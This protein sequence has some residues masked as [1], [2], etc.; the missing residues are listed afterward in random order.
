[1]VELNWNWS[2][3]VEF[4]LENIVFRKKISANFFRKFFSRIFFE[5]LLKN[6]LKFFSNFFKKYFLKNIFQKTCEIKILQKNFQ[7]KFTKK[8]LLT[9]VEVSSSQLKWV[10]MG[11]SWKRSR[12]WNFLARVSWNEVGV[13]NDHLSTK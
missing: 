9:L 11:W 4:F 13:I 12:E 7:K 2:K 3:W 1:L 8:F 6:F 5:F 10:E